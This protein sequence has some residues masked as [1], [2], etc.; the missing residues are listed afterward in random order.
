[1]SIKNRILKIAEKTGVLYDMNRCIPKI[2]E[3]YQSLLLV[4]NGETTI[5]E[6]IP[7]I[8]DRLESKLNTIILGTSET[9]NTYTTAGRVKI[10]GDD[11]LISCY[12]KVGK[13][14]WYITGAKGKEFE[15]QFNDHH[16][17]KRGT[18]VKLVKGFSNYDTI[19]AYD[20]YNGVNDGYGA[21][22]SETGKLTST[23]KI[24]RN[25]LDDT[26]RVIFTEYF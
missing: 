15:L 25:N 24:E 2:L 7:K 20:V 13:V 9:S 17:Q 12:G 5:K 8:L 21:F 11:V 22:L 10:Y 14:S 6:C 23:V 26:P 3:D 18:S 16:I 4:E 1:M 19:I